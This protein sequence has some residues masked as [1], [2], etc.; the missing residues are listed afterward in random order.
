[1]NESGLNLWKSTKWMKVDWVYENQPNQKTK[2][3]TKN[4]KTNRSKM[5][6]K[7]EFLNQWMLPVSLVP[8]T[9]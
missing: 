1:M 7:A 4:N 8:C 9:T 6:K 3:W 2:K 5:S